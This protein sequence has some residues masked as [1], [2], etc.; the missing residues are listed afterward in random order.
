MRLFNKAIN[1]LNELVLV[2]NGIVC[3]FFT[4]IYCF[5]TGIK[6]KSGSK[7]FG[8]TKFMRATDSIIDIGKDCRFRSKTTSNLIGINHKC[9]IATHTKM[10]RLKIGNNCGFSG[11]TIGCF[12]EIVFGDN[13][14]C[15]ANTLITDSDWHLNDPRAGK[16]KP[17]Y[18]GN[19]VWLG[20]GVIVLKG[21]S[22]GENS[23]IG[24]GS[25][26]TKDIPANVIAGGNPC[27]VL[28]NLEATNG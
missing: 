6:I 22:I 4:T 20:Y 17:I 10:A 23:V 27:K 12:T 19:N 13:V 7:F 14:N 5:F 2:I 21:V 1:K 9:I 18:I 8:F 11:T 16:A 15:G 3:S 24:A 25:V 26:V 28:K